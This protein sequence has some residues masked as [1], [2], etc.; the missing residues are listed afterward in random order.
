MGFIK[1][2]VLLTFPSSYIFTSQLVAKYKETV[3]KYREEYKW[4][5]DPETNLSVSGSGIG[6]KTV[7]AS[8]DSI[9]MGHVLLAQN[10]GFIKPEIN[11]WRK[12]GWHLAGRY[13][14]DKGKPLFLDP[15][16]KEEMLRTRGLVAKLPRSEQFV[17]ANALLSSDPDGTIPLIQCMDDSVTESD[18]Q[19][20]YFAAVSKWYERKAQIELNST[21]R[22]FY[23][24]EKARFA[25]S[26]KEGGYG[27]I[28]RES[29]IYP[30]LH[31]LRDTGF[32]MKERSE[33]SL[34]DLA[35]DFKKQLTSLDDKA[36]SKLLDDKENNL[37]ILL[38]ENYGKG[39][40]ALTDEEFERQFSH[41][42]AFYKYIGLIMIPY[43]DLYFS[44]LASSLDFSK[45]LSYAEYGEKIVQ[46]AKVRKFDFSTRIP[47]RRYIRA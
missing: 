25:K 12:Y 22:N 11:I 47:G 20:R 2:I 19:D 16:K 24:A 44:I 31:F 27:K 1:V 17:F 30:R 14:D 10:L 29:Q 45:S 28:H 35:K 4:N 21:R 46:L 26:E 38:A 23:A 40:V 32:V 9:A 39:L 3:R 37:G 18:L 7:V 43:E 8:K 41:F 36:V 34:S 33:F 42:T 13:S 5:E 15:Q 6:D